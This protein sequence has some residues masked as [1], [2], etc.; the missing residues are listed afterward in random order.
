MLTSVSAGVE[1]GMPLHFSR[2]SVTYICY[3]KLISI[4]VNHKISFIFRKTKN[5][6]QYFL[7]I[8]VATFLG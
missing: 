4:S 2:Y 3:L 7:I 8:Q 6:V 1:P 5:E